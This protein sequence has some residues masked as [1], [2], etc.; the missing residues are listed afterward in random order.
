MEKKIISCSIERC[1]LIN[2]IYVTYED[3][4]TEKIYIY[5]PDELTFSENEFIG[6]TREEA[7]LLC[8]QKDL[9]YLK[10]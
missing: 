3:N 7:Q 2:K 9:D 6:L 5:Y 8:Y 1:R 4:S 10:G